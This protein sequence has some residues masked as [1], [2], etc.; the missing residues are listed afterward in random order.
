MKAGHTKAFLR[1]QKRRQQY[2]MLRKKVEE[3]Y[4]RKLEALDRLFF[5]E[6]H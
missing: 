3:E 4:R 2:E 6:S 5:P 1:Q